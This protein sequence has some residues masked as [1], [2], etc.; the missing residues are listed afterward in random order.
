MCPGEYPD[1]FAAIAPLCGGA[2]DKDTSN[3][4]SLKDLPVWTFHGTADNMIPISETERIMNKLAVY[5]HIKFTRLQD[6]GHGIQ[7]LYEDNRI[8]DWLL[9]HCKHDAGD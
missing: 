1:M 9:Q 5:G 3:I 6:E 7:Y 4:C 2:N 8:F